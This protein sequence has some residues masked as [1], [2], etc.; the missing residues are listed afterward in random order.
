MSTT[1]A[2]IPY[3]GCTCAPDVSPWGDDICGVCS[4]LRDYYD[5]CESSIQYCTVCD[6]SH[7]GGEFG[8]L[9]PTNGPRWFEPSDP[10]DLYDGEEGF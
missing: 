10:R 1:E 6:G 4:E 5:E 9:C 7:D 3:P 2:P 8:E